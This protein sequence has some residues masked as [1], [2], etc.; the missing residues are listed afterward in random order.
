MKEVEAIIDPA[1]SALKNINERFDTMKETLL[2]TGGSA[3]ELSKGRTSTEHNS[4]GDGGST[5][6]GSGCRI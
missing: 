2:E 6:G 3:A 4:T 1:G 5:A